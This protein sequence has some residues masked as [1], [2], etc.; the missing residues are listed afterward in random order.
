MLKKI[1]LFLIGVYQVTLS[2]DHGPLKRFYPYGYCRF[3]PTCSEYT[4][5]AIEIY[6]VFKGGLMGFKRIISCN[7]CSKGGYDPV[8]K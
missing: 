4:Y 2:K 5:E 8:K 7:P 1:A 6:G 3:K